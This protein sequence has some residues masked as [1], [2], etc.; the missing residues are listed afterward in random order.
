MTS[1]K[2]TFFSASSNA[3]EQSKVVEETDE[4]KDGEKGSNIE[5]NG[6]EFEA[7]VR[8]RNVCGKCVESGRQRRHTGQAS[9]DVWVWE[10]GKMLMLRGE[11]RK[12]GGKGQINVCQITAITTDNKYRRAF[13]LFLGKTKGI[14]SRIK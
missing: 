3:A 5:N 10:R 9:L 7:S 14:V 12:E 2:K 6:E 4:R 8:V 1:P 11:W 13:F